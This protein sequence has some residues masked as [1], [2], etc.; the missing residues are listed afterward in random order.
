MLTT[1][2]ME[3]LNQLHLGRMERTQMFS[4]RGMCKWG[5]FSPLSLEE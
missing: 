4:I 3:A 2:R 5:A 1:S